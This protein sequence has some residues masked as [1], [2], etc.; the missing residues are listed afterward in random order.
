MSILEH[1]VLYSILFCS[2]FAMTKINQQFLNKHYWQI[3]CIPII[4]YSIVLGCR[5]GWGNDY[6]FYKKR[7]ENPFAY[8]DENIGFRTLNLLLHE[9]GLNYVGA[10][11]VYSLIFIV[12]AFILI[13]KYKANKY[14]LLLF[15][16]ATLL[17]STFT[18]RQS[19][20]TSFIFISLAFINDRKWMLTIGMSIVAYLI[21]PGA[22]LTLLVI[23]LFYFIKM[24]KPLPWELT[25]PLYIAATL[26]SEFLSQYI[27]PILNETLTGMVL[28]NKF[29]S[30][31]DNSDKWF[32]LEGSNDI[33]KQNIITQILS[34][35]FHISM[36]YIGNVFL[37][38][39]KK[40]NIIYIYNAVVIGLI[41]LRLFFTLE[42]LRRIANPLVSFYFI[43]IGYAFYLYLNKAQIISH[44]EHL[45][46][47]MGFY[48]IIVYLILFY[49]RFLLQSPDYIFFWNRVNL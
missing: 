20:A 28:N 13:Q 4:L 47:K 33:Y 3:V 25:I 38:K 32:S 40:T 12:A 39:T 9:L 43:P 27:F 21:H 8:K 44:K 26:F 30:Y 6:L 19:V 29:Q 22:I 15:L 5:Y 49:G 46:C 35:I 10:Y 7:F 42:I 41:L 31:I 23:A 48:S 34:T 17:Q 18:I 16:P 36:I 37:N 45:Y 14:M 11:I 1:I 2:F 24:Q